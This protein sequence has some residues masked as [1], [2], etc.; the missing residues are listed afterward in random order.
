[1]AAASPTAGVPKVPWG[2]QPSCYGLG[3]DLTYDEDGLPMLQTAVHFAS[4]QTVVIK[5]IPVERL[6]DE[7]NYHQRLLVR[8]EKKREGKMKTKKW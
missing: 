4:N 5:R 1:M 7:P 6:F 8:K 2:L 3:E